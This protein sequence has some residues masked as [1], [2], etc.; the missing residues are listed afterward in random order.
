MQCMNW[1]TIAPSFAG[2]DSDDNESQ[3]WTPVER[4]TRSKTR[5]KITINQDRFQQMNNSNKNPS[6]SR[7]NY[8]RNPI[9]MSCKYFIYLLIN[10]KKSLM[11]SFIYSIWK[12]A[13]NFYK[14]WIGS[15]YLLKVWNRLYNSGRFFGSSYFFQRV[16]L[17]RK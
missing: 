14:N 2:T 13:C 10:L 16:S 8:D 15:T 3:E 5:N 6:I 11:T 1:I 4:Q 9:E 12:R 7:E 17:L